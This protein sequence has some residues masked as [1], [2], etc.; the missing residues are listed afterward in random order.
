MPFDEVTVVP[1][2]EL[3]FTLARVEGRRTPSLIKEVADTFHHIIEQ[4]E[5]EDFMDGITLDRVR[6]DG[7]NCTKNGKCH[8]AS[9]LTSCSLMS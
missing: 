7:Y 8:Y 1:L 6:F 9:N 4:I 3:H 2:D 5:K